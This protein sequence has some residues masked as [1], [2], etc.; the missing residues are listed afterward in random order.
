MKYVLT[1]NHEYV[2]ISS[3][4]YRGYKGREKTLQYKDNT[5]N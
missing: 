1:S 5:T 3:V 2:T 4:L